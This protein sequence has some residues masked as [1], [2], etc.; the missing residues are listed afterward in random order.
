[1]RIQKFGA[2]RLA[3][4]IVKW[5]SRAGVEQEQAE[6]ILRLLENAVETWTQ[7]AAEEEA[8]KTYNIQ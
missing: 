6:N 3:M 7:E 8:Q 4:A 1:M 5:H 2:I